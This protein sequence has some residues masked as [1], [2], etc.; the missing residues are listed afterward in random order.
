MLRNH[1]LIVIPF[2][3]NRL[4]VNIVN[5]SGLYSGRYA[6]SLRTTGNHILSNFRNYYLRIFIDIPGQN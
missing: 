1:Y 4:Q 3:L 6:A 2:I 5:I